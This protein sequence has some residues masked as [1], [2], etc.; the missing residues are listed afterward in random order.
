MAMEL[1]FINKKTKEELIMA[2]KNVEF[3]PGDVI[4]TKNGAFFDLIG[5]VAMAID[6][7]TIV[8]ITGPGTHPHKVSISKFIKDSKK[9]GWI[10]LYRAND[11]YEGANAA[12]WM[13]KTYVDSGAEYVL[14]ENINSLDETYCSKMIFQAYHF[15]NGGTVWGKDEGGPKGIIFPQSVPDVLTNYGFKMDFMGYLAD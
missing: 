3:R 13:D 5:H 10:K 7:E 12:I 1:R 9:G 6:S 8:N 4:V 15:G 2:L 14:T 11:Y